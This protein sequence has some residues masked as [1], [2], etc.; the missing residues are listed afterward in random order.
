MRPVN[1]NILFKPLPSEEKSE[2]G[3]FVPDSYKQVN[4]KGTITAIGNKVTKCNVGDVVW[5]VKDWGDEIIIQGEKY[6]L[7]HEN[8]ILSKQ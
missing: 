5:R 1:H 7:M 4:N 3:I 6:Y 2:G 8:S